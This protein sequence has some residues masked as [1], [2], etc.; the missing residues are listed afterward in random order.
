LYSSVRSVQIRE[1]VAAMG[2]HP[3]LKVKLETPYSTRDVPL[4][5]AD[6]QDTHDKAITRFSV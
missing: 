3:P 5:L 4:S 6:G 1:P 2:I